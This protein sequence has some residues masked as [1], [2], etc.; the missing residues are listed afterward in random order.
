MVKN[1]YKL[2]EFDYHLPPELIAQEP[3]YPRDS[4]RL[5]IVSRK[6][7]II[8]E[9]IFRDIVNFLNKGDTLVLNDTR[10]VNARLLGRREKGGKIEVLLLRE[11]ERGVWETLVKPGKRAR[12]NDTIIFEK[13]GFSAKVLK[14]T[15]QGG[16]VL[17]F[18]SPCDTFIKSKGKVPLPPYIKREIYDF[19]RYQTVYAQKEGAIAA[20]TA[21]L[22]FTPHL[23]KKLQKKGVRITPITLHCGL[24][25]FRPV[26]TDDIRQHKMESEWIEISYQTA[27][28]INRAKK[29]KRQVIAVGTTSV[30]ALESIADINREKFLLKPFCSETNFYIVPGYQFKIVDAMITNFHTPCSTNLILVAAFLGLSL[31]KKAYSYAIKRNFRF[32]SFGDAMLIV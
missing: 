30:R 9:G 15:A 8:R 27:E 12:I 23:L 31:L 5:L 32:Y 25:T 1:C 28:T 6:E 2:E 17:K 21:G 19:N 11:K 26:K 22:H 13:D 7:G 16:R 18:S 3:I 10:V 4:S 29:E 24:A 20:P 14:K